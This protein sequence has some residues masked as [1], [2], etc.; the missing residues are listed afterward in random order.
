M[1]N[2]TVKTMARETAKPVPE[3][4]RARI[5]SMLRATEAAVP[6]TL[7]TPAEVEEKVA[8]FAA[9]LAAPFGE[10]DVV[11]APVVLSPRYAGAR[12]LCTALLSR[13]E[14]G[15]VTRVTSQIILHPF[16]FIGPAGLSWQTLA[17]EVAHVY[18]PDSGHGALWR[19]AMSLLGF[20]AEASTSCSH[21]E[22]LRG[23]TFSTTGK[24][25]TMIPCQKC[26]KEWAFGPQ[27]MNRMMRGNTIARCRC[28][29]VMRGCE[30]QCWLQREGSEDAARANAGKCD[31]CGKTI[32]RRAAARILAGNPVVKNGAELTLHKPCAQNVL[33]VRIDQAGWQRRDFKT[34][35]ERL[36]LHG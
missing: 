14:R 6:Y 20:P 3:R 34:S 2:S 1:K 25:A 17:H 7:P 19:L 9:K 22:N 16:S 30:I 36:Y 5:E 12:G 26:G 11:S 28:G 32:D 18:T 24:R 31:A 4:L 15:R 10:F 33:A 8:G 27:L 29:H 13:N 23:P 21:F 35:L